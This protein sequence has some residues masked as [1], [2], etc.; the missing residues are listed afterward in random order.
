MYVVISITQR[1]VNARVSCGFAM[2]STD[3]IAEFKNLYIA[4]IMLYLHTYKF[5]KS[6]RRPKQSI[7]TVKKNLIKC[8]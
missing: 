1:I 7:G 8:F 5:L 2:S 4:K 3:S 6:S